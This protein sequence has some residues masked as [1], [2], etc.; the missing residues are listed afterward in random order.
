MRGSVVSL[1][2][3]FVTG[4][5]FFAYCANIMLKDVPHQWRWLL[6]ISAVPAIIQVSVLSSFFSF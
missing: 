6:G 2:I 5:Q 1:N 3:L 4:G